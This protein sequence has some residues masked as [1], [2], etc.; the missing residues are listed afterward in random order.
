MGLLV[1]NR[2]KHVREVIQNLDVSVFASP[3]RTIGFL[4]GKVP[5]PFA[6]FPDLTVKKNTNVKFLMMKGS[7][8]EIS[9]L[10]YK[11]SGYS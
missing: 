3:G 6:K 10:M 7:G 5:L 2:H 8:P 4:L 1:D 9:P 11:F